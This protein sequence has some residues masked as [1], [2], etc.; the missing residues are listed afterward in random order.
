MKT[1]TIRLEGY[2]EVFLMEKTDVLDAGLYICI[3]PQTGHAMHPPHL[4]R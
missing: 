3:E 4:K 1:I 2:V